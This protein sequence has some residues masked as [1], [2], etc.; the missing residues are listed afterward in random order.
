MSVTINYCDMDC[1]Y[2]WREHYNEPFTD[3]DAPEELLEK[4]VLAQ[5]RLISGFGGFEGTNKEK[6]KQ[7]AD[8]TQFAISLTGETLYYPRLSGFI[9]ELN[10]RNFSSFVVTNGMLPDRLAVLEPPTQLYISLDASNPELQIELCKPIHKDPWDRL[11]RSLDIL[12]KLRSKTR[13]AVRITLIKG[14]N[15]IQPERFAELISRA[16]PMFVEVKAYMFV[17]A[18]CLRLSMDNMPRHHEVRS[19]AEEIAKYAGM[20]IIDEQEE[21]RVVLLMREDFPGRIMDRC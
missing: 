19:F 14:M 6:L 7:A 3:L 12:S 15:M 17:G 1:V 9:K 2:C 21:S 16:D 18:S 8:P 20:K 13:T 5:R 10:K 4:A 11:L